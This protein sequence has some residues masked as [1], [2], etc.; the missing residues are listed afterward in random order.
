[1]EQ[2]LQPSSVQWLSDDQNPWGVPVLD[3]RA[4]TLTARAASKVQQHAANAVSFGGDD[5]AAF[6]GREPPVTRTVGVGL[7]YRIDRMLADGSLF[8]PRDMDQKWAIFFHQHKI[9]LVRS[10]TREVQA[11]ADVHR[12]GEE[13][14]I[15]R[16]QGTFGDAN[17]DPAFSLR[18]LDYLIRSHALGIEHPAPLPPALEQT[19]D[20]AAMWCF[21][22]FGNL[23]RFATPHEVRA[24]APIPP[25]RTNST[26]H[27]A[28]ARGD[29]E[30]T[31]AILDAGVPADLIGRDGMPPLHW[32]LIGRNPAVHLLLLSRGSPVDIRSNGGVTG[33]METVMWKRLDE[34]VFLLEHGADPNA[35]DHRGF[36]AMH[37]AADRGELDFVH[38]LLRHGAFPRP[39]A[40]GLTPLALAEAKGH[41][42]V[43]E[44][45]SLSR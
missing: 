14:V 4:F 1:M 21:A 2:V 33:L 39:L 16:L 25:L 45:L 17:E 13:A 20:K 40:Q 35:V 38:L 34:A 22:M 5:G 32:S 24:P 23:A 7:R 27:I 44:A 42:A 3:V 43:V 29:L 9:L 36:T 30:R 31:R 6:I 15:T 37:R 41:K 28:A 10:W 12:E 11:T 19:P 8:L 18:I 26:L